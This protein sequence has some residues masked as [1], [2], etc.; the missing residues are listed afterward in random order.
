MSSEKLGFEESLNEKVINAGRCAGC[1]ACVV[2]CPFLCLEYSGETPRLVKD[3]QSCGICP[4]V[5]PRYEWDLQ[6]VEEQ[7][8]GRNRSQTEEFGVSRRVVLAK[9]VNNKILEACQDGGLVSALLTFALENKIVEAAVVSGI[10][11][12]KPFR[13]V[14]KLATTFEEVL[15]CS[16]TRYTYS[17]NLLALK[18]AIKQKKT[19]LAF[20]GI[21]C[22]IQALRKIELIPLKKYVT[23]IKFVIG[24]MCTESFTYK[25]LIETEVKNKLKIS[26]EQIKK[27]NI[28]G[29]IMIQTKSGEEKV[30]SL[31]EAKIHTRQGC[32]HCQDF[33]SELA[34]ISAG[35]L[36][37]TGWTFTII[38]TQ[39]GEEIFQAAEK[40][41]A[42]KTKP[43]DMDA[44]S[45]K[46]L[47]LLSRKKR[48]L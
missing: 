4:R 7:V 16:G 17:A 23:P 42:I 26:P 43:I 45:W 5:C 29:K 21:P 44:K 11:Q 24:L 37:L 12:E 13:A 6:K 3:C 25:G 33:S 8:F 2:V 41:G 9:S 35:G 1:A 31:K 28:K 10:D 46:L 30:L 18:E 20:V 15:K 14:P 38:R 47:H 36:G 39:K 27:M 19:S 32:H 40:A 22:H 34:D 48:G